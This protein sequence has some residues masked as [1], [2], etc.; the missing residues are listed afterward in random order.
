[1]DRP[2]SRRHGAKLPKP[3]AYAY[4]TPPPTKIIVSRLTIVAATI[5][6]SFPETIIFEIFLGSFSSR[7]ESVFVIVTELILNCL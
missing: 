4:T 1:M 2:E 5:T 6:K 3:P 7:M